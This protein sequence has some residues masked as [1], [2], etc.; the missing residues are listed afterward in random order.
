MSGIISIL[1]ALVLAFIAY[2]VLMGI[3]RVVVIVGIIATLGY[4]YSN[5]TLTGL[6]A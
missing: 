1:V 2:K 6:L 3:V 4:L 5:G